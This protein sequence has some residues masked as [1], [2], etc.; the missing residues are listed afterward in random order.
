ML[1]LLVGGKTL[2]TEEQTGICQALTTT[3]EFSVVFFFH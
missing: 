1:L 3:F 2:Y